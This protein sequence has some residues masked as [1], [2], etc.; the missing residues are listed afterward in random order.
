MENSIAGLLLRED[1]CDYFQRRG[2]RIFADQK[3]YRQHIV[4]LTFSRHDYLDMTTRTNFAGTIFG[5][6]KRFRPNPPILE[7][8]ENSVKI[9]VHVDTRD[10]PFLP[11]SGL[12]LNVSLERTFGDFST[13]GLFVDGRIYL[14]TW[15]NQRLICRQMIGIRK[16]ELAP[17][18]FMFVGGLGSLRAL[19][20]R[21]RTGS[22]YLLFRTY[23]LCGGDF[24]RSLPVRYLSFMEATSLGLFF[25]IGD[26]WTPDNGDMST[27]MDLLVDAGFSLLLLDGLFRIDLARRI[28]GAGHAWRL[29]CRLF[30]QI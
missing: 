15:G 14:S 28:N 24:F 26:A 10:N 9:A 6:D 19:P 5:G 17:Q 23:Y 16:G 11:H 29:T 12:F 27:G 30:D 21:Y 13:R 22:H 8:R 7:G 18:H 2:W 25:E 1:F 3:I 20:D 4:R